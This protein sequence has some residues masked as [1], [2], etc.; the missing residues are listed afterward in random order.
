M[1]PYTR[2]VYEIWIFVFGFFIGRFLLQKAL[3]ESVNSK[4][5]LFSEIHAYE[6]LIQDWSL[7]LSLFLLSRIRSQSLSSLFRETF[8][9]RQKFLSHSF[10]GSIFFSSFFRAFLI[11][12]LISAIT[13]FLGLSTLSLDLLLSWPFFVFNSLSLFYGFLFGICAQSL[14]KTSL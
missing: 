9:E 8:L 14:S 10:C 12:S 13:I 1:K 2:K 6:L 11:I 7:F 3:E 5:F 4:F